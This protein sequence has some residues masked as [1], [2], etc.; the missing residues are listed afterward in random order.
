MANPIDNGLFIQ[1]TS[2]FDVNRLHEINVTSPEFKE[3]LSRLYNDV[4]NICLALNKKETAFY[5]LTEFVPGD[6]Y[7]P[8]PIPLDPTVPTNINRLS[9]RKVINF[10]VLPNTGT[11]SVAHGLDFTSTWS[12]VGI[13]AYATDQ[14]NIIAIPIPYVSTTGDNIEIN[15]DATNV[16][17][18]TT[19]NRSSFNI[20]YVILEFLKY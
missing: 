8:N 2:I 13:K 12:F 6:Q 11:K 10:G 14:T 18:I 3:L 20:T 4:N 9:Y 7:F 19:S 5:Q 17:I 15:V 1:T 16:N